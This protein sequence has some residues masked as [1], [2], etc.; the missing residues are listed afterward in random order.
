M[1]VFRETFVAKHWKMVTV[2]VT[3]QGS[4]SVILF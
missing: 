2:M 4:K 3:G 1:W